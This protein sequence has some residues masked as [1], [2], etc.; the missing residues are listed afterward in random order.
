M[1]IPPPPDMNQEKYRR[2]YC[3]LAGLPFTTT[4]AQM[5]KLL[6]LDNKRLKLTGEYLYQVAL[7]KAEKELLHLQI[8]IQYP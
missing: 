6:E 2:A 4:D 5:A 1:P 3:K 7:L 8:K